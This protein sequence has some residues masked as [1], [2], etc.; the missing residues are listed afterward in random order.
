MLF[1]FLAFINA[2]FN[3]SKWSHVHI[4][5]YT[6]SVVVVQLIEDTGPR[7]GN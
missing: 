7:K 2:E 1:S 4:N 5:V 6:I 3:I